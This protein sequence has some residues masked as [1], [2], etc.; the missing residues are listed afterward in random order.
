ME[1]LRKNDLVRHPKKPDWGIGRIVNIGENGHVTVY[2]TQYKTTT[3]VLSK[4]P[5]SLIKLERTQEALIQYH[6]EFLAERNLPY[7]GIRIRSVEKARRETKC[8]NCGLSL[9][10]TIDAECT[11]CGWILCFCGAC[12]C[13][14]PQYGHRYD[15]RTRKRERVDPTL[16]TDE[17]DPSS[18]N[19]TNMQFNTFR[20]ALSFAKK[21][22]GSTVTR[23]AKE[24]WSVTL[25]SDA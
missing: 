24:S 16:P 20:E 4:V 17:N 3:L 19:G 13:G 14:H 6:K 23:S 9:D 10:S 2:F 12:G 8:Y 5:W 21:H 7:T 22:P 18:A 11:A 25:N 15:S 1:N